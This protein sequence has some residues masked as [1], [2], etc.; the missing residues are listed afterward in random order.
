MSDHL[1]TRR[2]LMAGAAAGGALAYAAPILAQPLGQQDWQVDDRS[3]P[4]RRHA[5]AKGLFCGSAVSAEALAN[6]PRLQAVLRQDCNIL[7]PENELKFGR[8]KPTADGPLQFGPAER[9]YAF[10]RANGMQMRGHNLLWWEGE[11]DWAKRLVPTLSPGQAGD[12][13]T[14]YIHDVVGY[15]R[16]RLVQW[17]VVNEPISAQNKLLEPLFTGKLGEQVIDLAFHAAREADPGTML[18]LNQNLVEQENWWQQ[19]QRTATLGLLE[20]LL[21]RGVPVQA[22]GI[23]SHLETAIPFSPANWRAFLDEV[24]GMGLKIMVTELDV[25][26]AGTGGDTGARDS[27]VASLAKAYL[28]VTLSYRECLGV[29]SWGVSDR[30]SWLNKTPGKA[31]KDGVPLRPDMRDPDYRRAPLWQAIADAIDAAPRR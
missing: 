22:L 9:I 24:T 27:A 14:S 30:D 21:K 12:L 29:V 28:D 16:G 3:P 10:A 31:R 7:V 13:L 20:R 5:A 4:L 19:H 11:P 25:S 26:D 2:D 23:E 15:W 6:D 1:L 18:V 8:V 17:D